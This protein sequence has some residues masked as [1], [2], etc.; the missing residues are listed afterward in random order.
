MC[1]ASF[2]LTFFVVDGDFEDDDLGAAAARAPAAAADDPDAAL[3]DGGEGGAAGDPEAGLPGGGE[4]GEEEV[5]LDPEVLTIEPFHAPAAGGTTLTVHGHNLMGLEGEGVKA[6]VGGQD[7]LNTV[8]IDLETLTCALPPGGGVKLSVEVVRVLADDTRRSQPNT[9][10]RCVWIS[11]PR[12]RRP[13]P[14]TTLSEAELHSAV[15]HP[16]GAEHL[17]AP[18]G[19]AARA[20]PALRCVGDL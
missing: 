7:C 2:Y 3:D 20:P 12:L 17:P 6:K 19:S 11:D 14:P 16:N 8:A 10:F 9:L 15:R 1:L 5:P 18:G 13:Q 4:E